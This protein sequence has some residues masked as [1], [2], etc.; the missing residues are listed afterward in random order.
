MTKKNPPRQYHRT[1]TT[2]IRAACHFHHVFHVSAPDISASPV[3]RNRTHCLLPAA[4]VPTSAEKDV[5]Y[6]AFSSGILHSIFWRFTQLGGLVSSCS[7]PFRDPVQITPCILD[8][9]SKELAFFDFSR[10]L[11]S[12]FCT[13]PVR[14]LT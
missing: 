8:A 6:P 12:C 3:S 4:P 1:H 14:S 7:A 9:I 2:A 13:H 11:F 5:Q 10:C